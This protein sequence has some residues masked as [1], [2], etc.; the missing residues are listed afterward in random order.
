[1]RTIIL[2]IMLSSAAS[3][4]AT[5]DDVVDAVNANA[6]TNT[7]ALEFIYWQLDSINADTTAIYGKAIALQSI[8]LQ[9]QT[10]ITELQD[11]INELAPW[12]VVAAVSAGIVGG[13]L[14]IQII[15]K[16]KESRNIW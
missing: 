9:T 4:Q 11:L 12:I 15:M 10:Q 1:M 16:A 14:I 7:Q 5:L 13:L 8:N 3:A 2:M 6:V